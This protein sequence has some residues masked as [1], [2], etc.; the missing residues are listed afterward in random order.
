MGNIQPGQGSPGPHEQML[1]YR[2]EALERAVRDLVPTNVNE[3]QLQGVRDAIDLLRQEVR[4]T[5][6]KNEVKHEANSQRIEALARALDQFK[7]W[8]LTGIIVIFLTLIGFF[9]SAY[10][11]HI[12]H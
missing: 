12:V 2:V 11:T 8:A 10:A 4:E 1:M 6:T 9:V 5:A 7:I 3:L